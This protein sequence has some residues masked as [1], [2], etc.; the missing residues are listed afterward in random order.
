MGITIPY[1]L[2]LRYGDGSNGSIVSAER[3]LLFGGKKDGTVGAPIYNSS[4]SRID[5]FDRI[6]LR[7][8][9]EDW[10][11]ALGGEY[12]STITFTSE[13]VVSE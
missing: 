4:G 11:K 1:S 10:G 12:S 9:S 3:G 8:T 13:I 5:V 7:A 6:I 2:V